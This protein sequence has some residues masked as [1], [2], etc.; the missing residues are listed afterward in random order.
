MRGF[1]RGFAVTIAFVIDAAMEMANKM[2]SLARS[3]AGRFSRLGRIKSK[4]TIDF[5]ID[6]AISP[7]L[8]ILGLE[9]GP[10]PRASK[11]VAESI[12]EEQ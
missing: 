1:S 12:I 2:G 9:S 7:S 4:E 6:S 5:I 3:D 11:F 8:E 10:V